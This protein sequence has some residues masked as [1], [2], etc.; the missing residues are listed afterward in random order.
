[1]KLTETVII[2]TETENLFEEVSSRGV[3]I[4]L[5]TPMCFPQLQT[6][7]PCQINKLAKIRHLAETIGV[8]PE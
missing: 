2:L 5:R 6:P 8:P 1:M 3:N 4:Y 7:L